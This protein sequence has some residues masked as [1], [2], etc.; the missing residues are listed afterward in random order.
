MKGVVNGTLFTHWLPIDAQP[1]N[2]EL[3]S[4]IPT[5]DLFKFSEERVGMIN[6]HG[7]HLVDTISFCLLEFWFMRLRRALIGTSSLRP[8]RTAWIRPAL[9]WRRMVLGLSEVRRP[10]SRRSTANGSICGRSRLQPNLHG[11]CLNLPASAGALR[12]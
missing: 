7:I 11:I 6:A 8:T 3:L 9:M 10:A 12:W 4:A 1:S 2:L 5:S